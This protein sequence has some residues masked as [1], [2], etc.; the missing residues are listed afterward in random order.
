MQPEFH[1][2]KHPVHGVL[3]IPGRPT[4]VF[5]TVCTK[6]R[7]PWLASESVHAL[8]RGVWAD[9][10]AW[11]LGRYVIMPDHVHFFAA[12]TESE[13]SFDHWVRYWKSWFSKRHGIAEQRWQT[14][15]WDVRMRNGTHF[16]ECW[17]YVRWN[18]VRHGLVSRPDE[19]PFQGEVFPVR[20]E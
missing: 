8:L 13:I 4:I 11:L 18:P 2:R 3:F 19:W 16:E 15:H 17:E 20:W 10:R 9:A 1:G 14:D 7:N 6:G 12:A 5:G